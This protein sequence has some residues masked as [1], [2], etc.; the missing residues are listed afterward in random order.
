[1]PAAQAPAADPTPFRA[2]TRAQGP[3]E[4]HRLTFHN[5]PQ[6]YSPGPTARS[7][8]GL[9]VSA[10]LMGTSPHRPPAA[11][12]ASRS[13]EVSHNVSS[14]PTGWGL[15]AGEIKTQ[16]GGA[17]QGEATDTPTLSRAC[18]HTGSL[19]RWGR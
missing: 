19:P 13:P 3:S 14:F 5:A 15:M 4:T 8:L 1:M 12:E 9:C 17:E 7:D 16:P 2:G 11:L 18:L 6:R 10:V